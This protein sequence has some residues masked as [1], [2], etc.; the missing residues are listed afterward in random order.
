M[1]WHDVPPSAATPTKGQQI[2]DDLELELSF[3]R[4]RVDPVRVFCAAVR[5]A[6]LDGKDG[7]HLGAKRDEE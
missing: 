4:L 5:A 3:G 1:A 2:V 6:C 7:C